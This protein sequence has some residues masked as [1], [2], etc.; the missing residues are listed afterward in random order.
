MVPWDGRMIVKVRR[1]ACP[2]LPTP[3]TQLE[4][5]QSFEELA[6]ELLWTINIKDGG[7]Y[8]SEMQLYL[9]RRPKRLLATL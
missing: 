8:F 3:N 5:P 6:R 1:S 4:V 9:R 7:F 2:G